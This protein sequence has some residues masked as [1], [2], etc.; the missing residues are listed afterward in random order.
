MHLLNFEEDIHTENASQ[1]RCS[2]N[3]H[4]VPAP[5]IQCCTEEYEDMEI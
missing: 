3:I 5:L 4:L 1:Y 2:L